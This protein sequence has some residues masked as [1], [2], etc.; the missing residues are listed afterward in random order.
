MDIRR[1]SDAFAEKVEGFG[2]FFQRRA[3]FNLPDPPLTMA[4]VRDLC[5]V[6][7]HI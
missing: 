1:R 5:V 2:K 7:V 6:P 4:H 3:P